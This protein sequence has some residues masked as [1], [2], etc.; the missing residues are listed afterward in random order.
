MENLQK[1]AEAVH[2]DFVAQSIK[3]LEEAARGGK[4]NAN[5]S[6]TWDEIK[7]LQ[8]TLDAN[9]LRNDVAT[10]LGGTATLFVNWGPLK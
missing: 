2:A 6:G 1:I 3:Q 8:L 9:E 4:F 5:L 7:A 10:Q